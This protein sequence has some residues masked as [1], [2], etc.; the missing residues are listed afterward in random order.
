MNKIP[1]G[2]EFAPVELEAGL[3][4]RCESERQKA[5]PGIQAWQLRQNYR[6]RGNLDD[7]EPEFDRLVIE[8]QSGKS[9]RRINNRGD[10]ADQPLALRPFPRFAGTSFDHVNRHETSS[11]HLAP[12]EI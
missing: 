4:F 9:A 12:P 2:Q 10:D 8:H 6:E 7:S 5:G 1:L 11:G 3:G